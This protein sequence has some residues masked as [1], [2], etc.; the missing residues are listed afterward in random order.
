M[1]TNWKTV[2]KWVGLVL[3]LVAGI[4]GAIGGVPQELLVTLAVAGVGF[5]LVVISAITQYEGKKD[6]KFWTAIA[7]VLIGSI[8]V[9]IGGV[10]EQMVVAMIGAVFLIVSLFFSK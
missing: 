8:V 6:W 9:V 10:T 5:A 3:I 7:L 2:C 4:I 1:S